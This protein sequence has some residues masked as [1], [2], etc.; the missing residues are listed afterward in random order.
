MNVL[1]AGSQGWLQDRADALARWYSDVGGPTV[2]ILTWFTGVF[3]ASL[4]VARLLGWIVV[5]PDS[6]WPWTEAVWRRLTWAGM[7]LVIAGAGMWTAAATSGAPAGRSVPLLVTAAL[8][9]SA[10]VIVFG[11]GLGFRLRVTVDV[12]GPDG[13]VSGAGTAYVATRIDAMGSG[14]PGGLSAPEGSDIVRLPEAAISTIPQARTAAVLIMAIR[15]VASIT[16]WHAHVT[17]VDD[18]AVTVVISRNGRQVDST[19][20]F[21]ADFGLP[22][23]GPTA[24]LTV[25][26]TY[27]LFKLTRAYREIRQ[28]LGGATRW[29]SYACQVL[30]GT[31]PWR[32]DA[33]LLTRLLA[34][35]VDT[36]PANASAWLNYLQHM[37]YTRP[38]PEALE[39]RVEL[40]ETLWR[41]IASRSKLDDETALRIRV[42]YMLTTTACNSYR[43]HSEGAARNRIAGRAQQYAAWLDAEVHDDTR[44]REKGLVEFL[45]TVRPLAA[46]LSA[47]VNAIPDAEPPPRSADR[48]AAGL[49]SLHS[50]Y[51]QA[52]FL[53]GTGRP[54]EVLDLLEIAVGNANL[55]RGA[56][57]DPYLVALHGHPRFR[58]ITSG[59]PE[60][61][62]IGVLG[63]HAEA[64]HRNGIFHPAQLLR[65]GPA[66]DH[67]LV[68]QLKVTSATM[69]WI[70][71]VC[72]L[73]QACPD[74]ELATSWI[75]MLIEEG[76]DSLAVLRAEVTGNRLTPLRRHLSQAAD[77]HD[78]M[79]PTGDQLRAWAARD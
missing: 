78:T 22:A 29:S 73:A 43:A 50:Y 19:V 6:R 69:A 27:I 75:S 41:D 10:G 40:L 36:D 13:T 51:T 3:L 64:L 63:P 53:A 32:G 35:A 21:A 1:A 28:G 60:I 23:G 68:D 74:A 5:R 20:I 48:P 16:P 37:R 7:G 56:A 24:L 79:P 47:H 62:A 72:E 59:P 18:H 49:A 34:Q 25:A 31:P 26:S 33:R 46:Q 55:R 44:P 42:L 9:S 57:A 15:A 17:L 76:I 52:C 14:H 8:S 77:A 45:E 12:R 70:R 38:Y 54:D 30:A 67:D 39:R 4:T 11:S 61:A 66:E 71:G 58:A 2:N 65:R